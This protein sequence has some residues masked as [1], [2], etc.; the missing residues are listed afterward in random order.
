MSWSVDGAATTE[1]A[2]KAIPADSIAQIDVQKVEGRR[3]RVRRDEARSAGCADNG[4]RHAACRVGRER[5]RAPW[6]RGGVR[7]HHG[8]D[9]PAGAK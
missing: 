6:R 8:Y 5:H 1:A 7:R 9:K 3:P 4:I 2:A